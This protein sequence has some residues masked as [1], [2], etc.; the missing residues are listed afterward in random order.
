VQGSSVGDAYARVAQLYIEMFGSGS[1]EHPD[2]LSFIRRHLTRLPGC[3]LDVGC[4]PGHLTN[5]LASLGA[6]TKGVDLVPAFIRYAQAAYP[7]VTFSIGS[8]RRL[9]ADNNSLAGILTWYSLIHT[10]PEELHEVLCEFRRVLVV[11]G[12]L[13]A[14]LFDG[15]N[16]EPFDH[17]VVTAYKWPLVAI[18]QQLERSGFTVVG[19][20]QRGPNGDRRAHM[21]VAAQAT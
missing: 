8:M 13:V 9:E 11:G 15:E 2:D 3:V 17:K 19:S 1:H 12:V 5:Y 18:T 10:P 21:A 20:I 6:E 7:D 4:G 16:V 14:G